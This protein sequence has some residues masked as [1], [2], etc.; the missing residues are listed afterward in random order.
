MDLI[1]KCYL[2]ELGGKCQGAVQNGPHTPDT[3]IFSQYYPLD[4]TH[5]HPIQP[6]VHL[7]K[8]KLPDRIILPL[9]SASDSL[10]MSRL[11]AKTTNS[12]PWV[13]PPTPSYSLWGTFSNSSYAFVRRNCLTEQGTS[14]CSLRKA[15]P[16]IS[17]SVGSLVPQRCN[18]TLHHFLLFHLWCEGS[19]DLV[20][21]EV[22]VAIVD[23]C[24]RQLG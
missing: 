3:E 19:T 8:Y 9:L 11:S 21:I 10:N 15:L 24:S 17:F 22:N 7:T 16:L 23:T 1:R 5:R 4:S 12:M 6:K 2:Y 18:T 20:K 14:P 13:S